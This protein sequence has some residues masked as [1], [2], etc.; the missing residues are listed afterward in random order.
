MC[1]YSAASDSAARN[2]QGDDV[3][4]KPPFSAGTLLPR[5]TRG[6]S[7]GRGER[8]RQR[9][10]TATRRE[11]VKRARRGAAS[12]VP[13]EELRGQGTC[14]GT[15]AAWRRVHTS[16]TSRRWRVLSS[17]LR[18]ISGRMAHY[19]A[20]VQLSRVCAIRHNGA[21]ERESTSL[22]LFLS[23]SFP[24]LLF[25][26]R[27]RLPTYSVCLSATEVRASRRRRAHDGSV[28][29]E[30]DPRETADTRHHIYGTSIP[31]SLRRGTIDRRGERVRSEIS[32]R[33]LCAL[34]LVG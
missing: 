22:A 7:P 10:R 34:P 6:N 23:F 26:T 18:G 17:G 13:S 14:P 19:S 20:G 32:R 11:H 30:I 29:D 5:A 25:P 33:R 1:V 27:F 12:P 21:T 16:P 9:Q 4:Q 2:L 31:R 28:R 8:L 3:R 24:F 15:G